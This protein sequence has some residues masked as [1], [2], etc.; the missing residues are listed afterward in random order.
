MADD[1]P[2]IRARL[3]LDDSQVAEV[4]DQV[5]KT[6]HTMGRTMAAGAEAGRLGMWSLGESAEN[7]AQSLGVPN[8]MSRQLG[9]SVERLMGGMGKLAVGFG[10]AGLA[11]MAAYAIWSK[12]NEEKKK[13][14][15]N[16]EKTVDGLLKEEGALFKNRIETQ[17]LRAAN[18]RLR[19]VKRTILD[20]KFGEWVKQETEEIAKLKNELKGGGP[21][22]AIWKW[23]KDVKDLEEMDAEE[24]T[25]RA[26][27]LNQQ[28][29]QKE[30]ELAQKRAE[31]K[32]Q[33]LNELNEL[34]EAEKKK[35]YNYAA[36]LEQETKKE[37]EESIKRIMQAQRERDLKLL[38]AQITAQ[39][40]ASTF[41]MMSSLG[42]KHARQWFTMYKMAAMSEA[43]ISTYAGAARALKDYPAPWS[44]AVAAS[45]IAMG[46]A[47]V[48]VIRAQQFQGGGAGAGG[49]AV[50]TF[51]ANPATGLPEG[52]GMPINLTLVINGQTTNIGDITSGV[53]NE[54]Y[55]NNG[56]M[57][58]F[59]VAVERT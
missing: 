7:L 20:Q 14:H 32:A 23:I 51:A 37:Q 17:E 21:W 42:T 30:A 35:Y 5:G 44:Y 34:N 29:N 33:R 52:N 53:L 2:P 11:A 50:G 8:Q 1:L 36:I 15:E 25:R 16:L 31:R 47:K 59:T 41:Q 28:I 46:M 39:N 45:V 38:A 13:E 48:A 6:S 4:M 10:I 24:R 55:R 22:A 12:I 26:V 27:E 18:E 9:N 57:G 3:T 58:G 19:D 49:G 56:S 54:L 43:I 40:F